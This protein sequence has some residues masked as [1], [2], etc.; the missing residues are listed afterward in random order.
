MFIKSALVLG[1]FAATALA[2]SKVLFFTHVPNPITD[3]EAAAITFSTCVIPVPKRLRVQTNPFTYR[4]DTQSPVTIILRKGQ[5][6]DL[7]TIE[8]LTDNAS[9][10]QYVWTP[11]TSLPNGV[12]YA[13]EIT[14]G[15]NGKE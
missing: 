7:Q 5:S 4:N 15:H 1:A 10:S 9:G 11:P 12:D 8:T 3:G 6:N 14:V 2:Q 13:L